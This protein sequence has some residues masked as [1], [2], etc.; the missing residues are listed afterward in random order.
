MDLLSLAIIVGGL[1]LYSLISGRLRGTI[2]TAPLV[3]VGFGFAVGTGGLN[4]ADVDVGHSAIHVIA[5]F[6]LILV[7]FT[8]AARIDLD[9]VR[10]DHNLPT[11]MLIIG[12]P[13]AILAGTIVATQ[14]FPSFSLWEAALL[15]ALL[16]PT[17]AALGQSVI[18]ARAVPVRIR[19]AINIE[20][21]LND[22]IALP[23]VLL[24]AALA[25]TAQGATQASEWVRFGLL[26]VIIGPFAGVVIGYVGA[27]LLD[28]TIERGWTSPAFQGIGILSL[29][30]LTYVL[31]EL[32]GGNGF[33]AAF[34]GGMVFGH[35][36]RHP[37]TF[38]FEFMESEGQ[39]LMLI[40]FLIFGAALL[41]EGIAHL[42]P[43]VFLYAVL[44]LT[45]IRMV[46]IAISLFGSGLGLP[47]HLFLG[48][49]GPRGLASILFV[50]LILEESD[51]PHRDELLAVTVITVALS[52]LLHGV[53]AAP[54]ARRYGRLVGRMGECEESRPAA[55]LP[56][57][58]GHMPIESNTDY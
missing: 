26:Q 3:F 21:G 52:V 50:L 42:N 38:L 15:A 40:T 16:A 30:V 55:E 43:I 10:L 35:S 31:A 7:L 44:S 41:P 9:R 53:S 1:L 18:S 12:L 17:D 39:L 57:R 56:L 2:V 11:R 32:I 22:G 14:L 24:L 20:S 45:V 28:T 58:E 48:W 23:A 29:A 27:R 25:G 4:L 34:I 33:I 19:Q 54:L 8:D 49:F 5:E 51:V 47:S 37:C 36:I 46:P 13:L 6:T